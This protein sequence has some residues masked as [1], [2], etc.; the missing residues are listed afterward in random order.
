MFL[1]RRFVNLFLFLGIVLIN[2]SHVHGAACHGGGGGQSIVVLS[3]EQHY[4]FGVAT[5]YGIFSGQ[6]DPYGNYTSNPQGDSATTLT[7]MIGMAYRMTE[8]SQIS[9]NIPVIYKQ[10]TFS[11]QKKYT[12]TGIGDILSEIKYTLWDDLAF[13][14]YHPHLSFYGGFRLPSGTSIYNSSNLYGTDIVGEGTTIAHAGVSSSKTYHPFKLSFDGSF[15]YPF[16]KKVTKIRK[17]SLSTPY[18]L[19]SGNRIQLSEGVSYFLNKHWSGSLGLNQLWTFKSKMNAE[20]VMASRARLFTTLIGINYAYDVSWGGGLS[21]A[22][23]FPF[24]RYLANQ[25]HS[26][27]ISLAMTYTGF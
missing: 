21:Y 26:Q 9:L 10:Q 23:A 4:Q 5:S 14:S 24:Y 27:T 18:T 13:L 19:K 1:K 3:P 11:S 8:N 15:L 16:S 25:L 6:F 17:I 2:T 12:H 20:T 7:N 22:T